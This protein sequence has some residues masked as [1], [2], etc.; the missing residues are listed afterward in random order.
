MVVVRTMA[1]NA[2][3]GGEGADEGEFTFSWKMFTSWDYLIGNP[4]T[5][6]NKYASITTSFKVEFVMSL[7]GLVCPPLFEW[8]AELE[9]YHPRIA[10]KWQLGR[11]FALFLGNLYTFLFAL[12]DEV[13]RRLHF[14]CNSKPR[15][16]GVWW[17]F[18]IVKKNPIKIKKKRVCEAYCFGMQV[19]YLTIL[20]GDFRLDF[21][22]M[23]NLTLVAMSW[24]SSS[25]K[26]DMDGSFLCP[27]LVGLN[28]LRLLTSMY[29]QCW[30]VMSCN[31]LMNVSS[32]L[33]DQIISTWDFCLLV[34][35]LSL[36]PVVY[37]MMTLPPSFDCGPFSGQEKM[38]DVVMETIQMIYLRL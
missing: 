7:L 4:E 16:E 5:A 8:I 38:Y 9:D 34:L 1:R 10:L 18:L 31:V 12:F 11:I 6:D 3:E 15:F 24:D 37:T 2:N 21:L 13:T 26:D 27:G 29:Y 22:H 19:N 30:A 14:C 33:P 36:L 35:F 23:E 32:R 28:V 17:I 20:I 25:I